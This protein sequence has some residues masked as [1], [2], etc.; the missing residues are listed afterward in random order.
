MFAMHEDSEG[1]GFTRAAL[2]RVAAESGDD[3][4]AAAW[5]GQGL[6]TFRHLSDWLSILHLFEDISWLVLRTGRAEQ[7]TRLLGAADAYRAADGVRLPTVQRAGHDWALAA[8]Q[9]ALGEDAFRATWTA[10][11]SSRRRKPSPT[12]R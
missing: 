8:A 4:R 9:T 6:D 5:F 2:G 7:A 1:V 10:G 11:R 12:P 3:E